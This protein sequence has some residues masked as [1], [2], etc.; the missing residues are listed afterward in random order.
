L[1]DYRYFSPSEVAGLEP[2]L[3][4]ALDWARHIAGVPFSLSETVATGG[5]HALN[6]SH[7]RGW[8]VDIR[9]SDPRPRFKIIAALIKVG[10]T[11]IGIYD[12][13]I[14][15]DLDPSLDQEVTWLGTS[16]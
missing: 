4:Y 2:A 1:P 10:F 12:R 5:S 14:H 6:T 8:G 13:H 16:S 9:C 11:R 3:V 15:A 7:G